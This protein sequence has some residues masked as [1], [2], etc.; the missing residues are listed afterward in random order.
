VGRLVI[1]LLPARVPGPIIFAVLPSG[2][3]ILLLL[4]ASLP[5]AEL[6]ILL[7][8]LGGLSCSGVF[9]MLLAYGEST[10]PGLGDLPAGWLVAS[11]QAGYGIAA[12]GGGLLEPL[13]GVQGL[14]A[15]AAVVALVLAALAIPISRRQEEGHT[16]TA[17]STG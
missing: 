8:A 11:Y 10:F 7:F 12:F 4:S 3:A 13:V 5:A 15:V 2:I 14:F 16:V 6:G 1:A 17:V 9:P